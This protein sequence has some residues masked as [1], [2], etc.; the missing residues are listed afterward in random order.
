MKSSIFSEDL[1]DNIA[2]IL[3]GIISMTESRY[4]N[5][6][7]LSKEVNVPLHY[8]EKLG[9]IEI[10]NKSTIKINKWYLAP[11]SSSPKRSL[12]NVI[13]NL[14]RIEE[15]IIYCIFGPLKYKKKN[16]DLE[17]VSVYSVYVGDEEIEIYFIYARVS[18]SD[19]VKLLNYKKKIVFF[20]GKKPGISLFVSKLFTHTTQAIRLIAYEFP[21]NSLQLKDIKRK[22]WR[23][24]R[25]D[26]DRKILQMY[27]EMEEIDPRARTLLEIVTFNPMFL[28]RLLQDLEDAF[29]K[30]TL[31]EQGI[32]IDEYGKKRVFNTAEVAIAIALKRFFSDLYLKRIGGKGRADIV[33]FSRDERSLL[34][35]D[36]KCHRS[37]EDLK[38]KIGTEIRKDNKYFRYI[39]VA[40]KEILALNIDE[41]RSIVMVF[42][43]NK[44]DEEDKIREIC[45]LIMKHNKEKEKFDKVY[46]VSFKH[47]REHIKAQLLSQP[48]NDPNTFLKLKPLTPTCY[49][50]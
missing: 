15:R 37:L 29:S 39:P 18:E 50:S 27:K 11:K 45:E 16:N 12:D 31:E 20:N 23:F 1:I 8:L 38:S 46:V 7:L 10:R 3:L 41:I 28:L 49:Y 40:Q 42:I 25:E 5:S 2:L 22:I 17:N 35:I 9:F 43:V 14:D 44:V 33:A 47:I 6:E 32:Y 36:V 34:I 24:I 19:V 21:E 4:T 30:E 48:I 13:I 26:I